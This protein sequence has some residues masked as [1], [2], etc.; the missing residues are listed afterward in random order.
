M[1]SGLARVED[2]VD[3]RYARRQ[4]ASSGIDVDVPFSA[5]ELP[6]REAQSV[7]LEFHPRQKAFN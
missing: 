6:A 3:Y 2:A 1:M 4:T 7:T 5:P